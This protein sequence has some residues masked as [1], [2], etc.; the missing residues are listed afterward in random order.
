[1]ILRAFDK[2][3]AREALDAEKILKGNLSAAEQSDSLKNRIGLYLRWGLD[4]QAQNCFRE[5]SETESG[6]ILEKAN[7]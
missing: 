6:H 7:R 5:L 2:R 3:E 4:S 1:M